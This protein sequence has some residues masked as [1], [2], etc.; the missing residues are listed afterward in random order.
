MKDQELVEI[1]LGVDDGPRKGDRM[2]VFQEDTYLG[3]VTVL[4]VAAE[5][6]VTK[7]ESRKD[8]SSVAMRFGPAA[9]RVE[10]G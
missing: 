1:S 5:K 3:E 7:I 9:G 10:G 6:S 4:Q 8:R 2:N